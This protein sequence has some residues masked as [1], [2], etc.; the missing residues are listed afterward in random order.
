MYD[1]LHQ[2]GHLKVGYMYIDDSYLHV[3][4]ESNKDCQANTNDTCDLF[5]NLGF[6]ALPVKSVW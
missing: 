4:G 3:Q 1:T 6:I 2:K 5:T